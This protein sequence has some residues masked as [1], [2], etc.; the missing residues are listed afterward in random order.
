MIHTVYGFFHGG[1]PR[2]FSPDVECCSDA[3]MVR[4][5]AACDAWDDA[6]ASG[7]SMQPEVGS[8][9]SVYGPDGQ[10]QAHFIF[11]HFGIGVSTLDCGGPPSECSCGLEGFA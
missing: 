6:Q 2:T 11:S 1:D 5:K 7:L 3:E 9:E 4:W 10:L 8:C